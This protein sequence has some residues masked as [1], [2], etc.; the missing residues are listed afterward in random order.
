MYSTLGGKGRGEEERG[1]PSVIPAQKPDVTYPTL[2]GS[3][4]RNC[5]RKEMIHPEIAT[6]APWYAKTKADPKIVGLFHNR[7]L[8]DC[9]F[10]LYPARE[11]SVSCGVLAAGGESMS[12]STS[13]NAHDEKMRLSAARQSRMM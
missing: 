5:T 12:C 10:C 3:P 7:A 1:I 2:L 13:Q 6:S 9:S 11:G 4:W 8:T